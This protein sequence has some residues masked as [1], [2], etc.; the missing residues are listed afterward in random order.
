MTQF[1]LSQVWRAEFVSKYWQFYS[2]GFLF[3]EQNLSSIVMS[4]RVLPTH[5]KNKFLTCLG[6]LCTHCIHQHRLSAATQVET[7]A[8]WKSIIQFFPNLT[9]NSL[10][11]HVMLNCKNRFQNTVFPCLLVTSLPCIWFS[12]SSANTLFPL[13]LA[14]H[15]SC[16]PSKSTARTACII[17][18]RHFHLTQ[19]YVS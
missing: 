6:T 5:F 13:C 17:T 14:N 18:M 7:S 4:V 1:A 2:V 8:S 15:P 11:K 9:L 10:V 19:Y 12:V 3:R 16:L